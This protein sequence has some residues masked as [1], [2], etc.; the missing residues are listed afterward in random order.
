[1]GKKPF[2]DRLENKLVLATYARSLSI[3]Y[4]IWIQVVVVRQSVTIQ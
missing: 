2:L 4:A 1:M 3:V